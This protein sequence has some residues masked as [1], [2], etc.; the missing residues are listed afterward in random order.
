[1]SG[2]GEGG[3][4]RGGEGGR[5]QWERYNEWLQ[6]S[7]VLCMQAYSEELSSIISGT[8]TG[9]KQQLIGLAADRHTL[10]VSMC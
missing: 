9:I 2:I 6:Q 7:G 4:K 3:R 5:G 1:M 8:E 10:C